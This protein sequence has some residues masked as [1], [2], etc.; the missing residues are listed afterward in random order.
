MN[1]NMD[2]LRSKFPQYKL[3]LELE[4]INKNIKNS[5]STLSQFMRRMKTP[6]EIARENFVA[7]Y[8]YST[9]YNNNNNSHSNNSYNTNGSYS[10]TTRSSNG[11]TPC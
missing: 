9:N 11:Y 4:S 7:N 8:F 6:E 1:V 2:N 5:T 3:K 10:S